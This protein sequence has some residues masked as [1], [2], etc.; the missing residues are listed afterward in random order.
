LNQKVEIISS[1]ENLEVN[2]NENESNIQNKRINNLIKARDA[3]QEKLNNQQ[4]DK[5]EKINELGEAINREQIKKIM[6]KS[7]ELK[8][9]F[10]IN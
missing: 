4:S 2:D 9:K 1:S 7:N 10:L 6:S 8:S 5:E 3:R